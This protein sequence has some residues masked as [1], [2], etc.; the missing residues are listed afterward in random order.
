MKKIICDNLIFEFKQLN[1][2]YLK[3]VILVTKREK[4]AE[5]LNLLSYMRVYRTTHFRLGWVT[6]LCF[7]LNS[8]FDCYHC[9]SFGDWLIILFY[10]KYVLFIIVGFQLSQLLP[11]RGHMMTCV[12]SGIKT[13][14]YKDHSLLT[15]Q[16]TGKHLSCNVSFQLFFFSSLMHL[17][18][19]LD[20]SFLFLFLHY[21]DY[22]T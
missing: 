8:L 11:H 18:F 6:L 5:S 10:S 4:E 14:A 13:S 3:I 12:S 7:F 21:C 15:L 22:L 17:I 20:F 1:C 19:R 16:F 9:S 2:V